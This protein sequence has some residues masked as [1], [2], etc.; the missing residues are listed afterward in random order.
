MTYR[1]IALNSSAIAAIDYDDAEDPA[2][3][4]IT[5]VNGQTYDYFAVPLAVIADFIAA[6]SPGRFYHAQI[7]GLY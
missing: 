7:K 1:S 2:D 6:A 4:T 3:L 5:F